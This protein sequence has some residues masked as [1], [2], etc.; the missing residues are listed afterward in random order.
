MTRGKSKIDSSAI[1]QPKSQFIRINVWSVGSHRAGLEEGLGLENLETSNASQLVP[2]WWWRSFSSTLY[3]ISAVE[4]KG[5]Y[6]TFAVTKS[7]E[8]RWMILTDTLDHKQI[9]R[10]SFTYGALPPNLSLY[11]P[12]LVCFCR[13]IFHNWAVCIFYLSVPCCPCCAGSTT[14]L[15]KLLL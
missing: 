3:F 2:A 11:W 8:A 10:F 5:N 9:L 6:H 4:M 1:E 12:N 14:S 7:I 13:S 15:W